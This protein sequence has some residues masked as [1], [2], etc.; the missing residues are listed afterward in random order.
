MYSPEEI[1]VS[2]PIAHD[3]SSVICYISEE[4]GNIIIIYNLSFPGKSA[5]THFKML[6]YDPETNTSLVRCLP[7]TGR[8]HQIRV[9]LQHL[10]ISLS[11]VLI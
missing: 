8:T 11:F 3:G 7:E 1:T 5:V 2:Q 9:H 4:T 10:G 6:K